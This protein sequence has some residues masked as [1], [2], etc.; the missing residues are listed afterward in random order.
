MIIQLYP[1]SLDIPENCETDEYEIHKMENCLY[2]RHRD[3][4][5]YW[6]SN[7]IYRFVTFRIID[8]I[9]LNNQSFIDLV[10]AVQR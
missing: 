10:C 3:F 9:V 5:S 4:L 8:C 1:L 2:I 6:I 7:S